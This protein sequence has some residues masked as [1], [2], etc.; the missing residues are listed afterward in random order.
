MCKW[1][2]TLLF[3]CARPLLWRKQLGKHVVCH[4]QFGVHFWKR[5]LVMFN[6]SKIASHVLQ[7]VSFTRSDCDVNGEKYLLKQPSGEHG[8]TR[9]GQDIGQTN[10][11][12]KFFPMDGRDPRTYKFFDWQRKRRPTKTSSIVIRSPGDTSV[13]HLS[14]RATMVSIFFG[15]FAPKNIRKQAGWWN[16]TCFFHS[17]GNNH[18]IWL[19]YFSDG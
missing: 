12:R 1:L 11:A 8:D 18:P 7:K 16:G 19:S 13:D 14:D 5:S 10:R 9:H 3:H 2:N 17:V 15:A 6:L 4:P